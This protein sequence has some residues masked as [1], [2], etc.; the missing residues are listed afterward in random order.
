MHENKNEKPD[1]SQLILVLSLFVLIFYGIYQHFHV[2]G[3]IN[4][5]SDD[6]SEYWEIRLVHT[7]NGF[8]IKK[9]NYSE[10]LDDAE[11]LVNDYYLH[12][13]SE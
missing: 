8:E 4:F 11:K 2:D 3:D 7:S 10:M 13:E 6:K 5:N 1:Y 12:S 9:Y